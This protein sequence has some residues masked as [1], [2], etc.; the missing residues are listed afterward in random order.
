MAINLLDL[1][2]SQL[3][4]AAMSQIG[5]FLGEDES[6]ASAGMAAALPAILGSVMQKGS[7]QDGAAGIMDLLSGGGHDG[8]MFDN[9]GSLLG[10]GGSTNSMMDTGGTLL[11][12]FMGNKTQAITD[13]LIKQTGLGKDAMGSVLRMAAPMLIGMIGKQVST[14]GLNAGGLMSLLSG[15]KEFIKGA[16]PEGMGNL[17]GFADMGNKAKEAVESVASAATGA[18]TV[19]ASEGKSMLSRLLPLAI[20]LGLCFAG[21]KYFSGED[22]VIAD[23]TN[24]TTEAAKTAADKAGDAANLVAATAEDAVDATANAGGN[25]ANAVGDAAASATNAMKESANKALAN[26]KLATGSAG[27]GLHKLLGGTESAVGKTVIFKNLNFDTGSANIDPTTAIEVENLAAVLKAY[28][29]VKVEIG[30]HTDNA[31]D[32]A[33][34]LKLSNN[35]ASAVAKALVRKG[36]I[37]RSRVATFGFGDGKPIA[38]NGTAEGRAANRRIEVMIV[39]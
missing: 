7:T 1:V 6:K 25:A 28:P 11:Q 27:E 31:G 10:G 19:A 3:G 21:Y 26:I 12:F 23:A 2:Q 16:L 38:D 17:L 39:E 4:G 9:L 30:G 34:N 33:K 36:G 32:A 14:S 29:N 24:A 13:L 35:R 18:A 8:S 22:N 5:K 20:I 15:Q 37:D